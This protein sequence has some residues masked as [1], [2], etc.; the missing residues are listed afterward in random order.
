MNAT[1][2]VTMTSEAMPLGDGLTVTFSMKG[3]TLEAEWAPRVPR[4][5]KARK[6]L[7]AYKRA[8][9]EFIG[10]LVQRTGLNVLVVDL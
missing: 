9:D 4:G 2:N 6:Y 3:G 7:P 10:R 1:A 8:P 5:R